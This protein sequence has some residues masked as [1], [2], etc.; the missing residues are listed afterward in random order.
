MP[1]LRSLFQAAP[2]TLTERHWEPVTYDKSIR[3]K[4]RMFEVVIRTDDSEETF[5]RHSLE[6]AQRL[7]AFF[8]DDVYEG[9][10]TPWSVF[11]PRSTECATLVM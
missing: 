2:K 11:Y 8:P 9:P 3:A 7:L 10:R 6:E 5:E 1:S 4:G